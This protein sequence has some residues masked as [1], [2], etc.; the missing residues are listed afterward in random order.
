MMP[1]LLLCAE[2]LAV[3]GLVFAVH[4]VRDRV[5]LAPYFA[6]LGVLAAIL[7]WTTDAGIVYQAGPLTL[8]LGSVVFF[9][10]I[11]FGIFLLYIFDGVQ[12]AQ[13]GIYTVVAVSI[14]SPALAALFQFQLHEIDPEM[15]G[16]F[17]FSSIRVY[18]SSTAAMILDFLFIAILWELCTRHLAH[19]P[20][21]V[22][23][24]ACL[25]PTYWLDALMFNVG[26]FWGEPEFAGILEGN[27]I[28]RAVLTAAVCPLL[29]AYVAW[30]ERRQHHHFTPRSF[31]AILHR[32]ARREFDLFVA[33][34]EIEQRKRIEEELRRRDA[35]LKTLAFAA[36]HMLN[37]SGEAVRMG[38]ILQS[39]ATAAGVTRVCLCENGE[40]ASGG[41]QL[42]Q[43]HDW[44][45][46]DAP[47][48]LSWTGVVYDQAGLLRWEQGLA[49]GEAIAGDVEHFPESERRLLGARGVTSI[50]VLPVNVADAWWGFISFEECDGPRT[51]PASEIDA[52]RTA[53]GTLGAA[54][55]RARMEQE[56]RTSEERL[57]LALRGGDLGLWD[58]DIATDRVVFN[59]R[60]ANMLGFELREIEPTSLAWETL[61]H[62]EDTAG[63]RAQV[64]ATVKGE[65]SSFEVE[66]RMRGRDGVWRWILNKGKVVARAENGRALRA[67]GTHL[68]ITRLKQTEEALRFSQEMFRLMYEESPMGLILCDIEGHFVQANPAFCSLVGYTEA[69]LL[70]RTYFDVTPR[71]FAAGE[72]AQLRDM[73]QTGRYGPFEIAYLHK[74]GRRIP[75]ISNGCLVTGAGGKQYIWSILEDIREHKAAEQAIAEAHRYQ[76][77]I[78]TR[79]EE[80]LLRGRPPAGLKGV[81][82]AVINAPTG[83]MDGDFTD[84]VLLHSACFDVLVGDVMG[85][86]ILAALVS[87]GAKSHFLRALATQLAAREAGAWPRPADLVGAVHDN[88]TRQLIDLDCFLTLCY[89]R[90]DLEAGAVT[91]VDCGHTKTIRFRA[92]DHECTFLEGENVPIGFLEVEDYTEVTTD[93]RPGDVFFFYSDGLTESTDAS[94]S[95]FGVERLVESIQLHASLDAAGLSRKV[96]EA[97]R[98]FSGPGASSDDQTCVAVRILEPEIDGAVE[99]LTIPAAVDRLVTARAF[100]QAYLE[101]HHHLL[102]GRDEFNRT[103]LAFVEA[104]SNIIKH[105]FSG[106]SAHDIHIE[107]RSSR[108]RLRI[109][110]AHGGMPFRPRSTPLPDPMRKREGGY[111]LY[112]MNRTFNNIGYESAGDGT[113]SLILVKHFGVASTDPQPAA[114]TRTAPESPP[115]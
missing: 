34:R 38:E 49:C 100:L 27:L 4:A 96:L 110:I 45:P 40:S 67:T 20:L 66:L 65:L 26:A 91:F 8:L 115:A 106:E 12:A 3:Y 68:D 108:R 28:S 114:D 86:G 64:R 53:A 43:R 23:I 98:E 17:T 60:W 36:E 51:W 63:L 37:R 112:I 2:A 84:F 111:G 18:V 101:R 1:L 81:D 82:V 74:D 25:L 76:R 59:E 42:L 88:I 61:V 89:A 83:H 54:I 19:M 58:W 9:T 78:E 7:R 109:A 93:L 75:V 52:L 46:P 62:P 29:T 31:M 16:S 99:S 33:H 50:L 72:Q 35:I 6:L 73:Q 102:G 5:T 85:K 39:L 14:L 15:A 79:I 56:L 113:Q 69:E 97:V 55:Q 44:H 103:I 47:E 41:R 87:A 21:Y 104:L 94:G 57:E 70:E 22:R 10:A 13:I 80:T 107:L 32:S 77:E 11:L 92:P 90:F 30:E 71:D 95:M 48:A 24:A 105:A